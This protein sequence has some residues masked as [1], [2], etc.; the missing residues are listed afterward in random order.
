MAKLFSC[1]Q[2]DDFKATLPEENNANQQQ[3]QQ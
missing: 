1:D 3:Q 2:C